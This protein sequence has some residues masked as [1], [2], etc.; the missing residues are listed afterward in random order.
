[1]MF[2]T[3]NSLKVK[4]DN[5]DEQYLD[6]LYQLIPVRDKNYS[7]SQKNLKTMGCNISS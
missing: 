4:I 1:M 6:I 2:T 3:K 7:V 5:V